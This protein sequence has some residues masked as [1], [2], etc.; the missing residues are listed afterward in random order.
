MAPTGGGHPHLSDRG[1]GWRAGRRGLA[2]ADLAL[3]RQGAYRLFSQSLLCPD[4][5]RLTMLATVAGE[6]GA[7]DKAWA[8]FDFAQKWRRLLHSLSQFRCPSN[9]AIESE[10]ASLFLANVAGVPCPI[11]ESA[12]LGEDPSGAGWLLA[13]LEREYG[14]M[15]LAPSPD[16]REPP[17]HAAVELEFMSFLCSREAEAWSRQR[18]ADAVQAVERERAFLARHLTRWFPEL[19]SRVAAVNRESRFA[20]ITDTAC[21]FFAHDAD[22][23]AALLERFQGVTVETP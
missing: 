6:T 22:L 12:Y 20:V 15:G 23:L 16:H 21:S 4:E 5:A 19:A 17:D 13:Q 8:S 14:S 3:L 18:L 9:A 2:L 1:S 11:Y 7:W 10:Y